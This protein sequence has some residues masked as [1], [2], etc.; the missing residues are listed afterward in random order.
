MPK[1][2]QNKKIGIDKRKRPKTN[3]HPLF[4]G[5]NRE[6]ISKIEQPIV[7][8]IK[9]S[10][11]MDRTMNR[12]IKGEYLIAIPY[13]ITT[14]IQKTMAAQQERSIA[15]R[16]FTLKICERGMGRLLNNKTSFE[17]YKVDRDVIRL[18]KIMRENIARKNKNKPL[19]IRS[20]PNG[21]TLTNIH[22]L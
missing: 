1:L 6:K 16:N 14:G 11:G 8:D 5:K 7:D 2:R 20:S 18:E 10:R 21:K 13:P 19:S 17:V 4:I 22:P 15:S 12:Y 3:R 9:V